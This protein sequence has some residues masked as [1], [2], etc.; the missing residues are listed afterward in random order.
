MY[1]ITSSQPPSIQPCPHVVISHLVMN[2]LSEYIWTNLK[3]VFSRSGRIYEEASSRFPHPGLSSHEKAGSYRKGCFMEF[4]SYS[5]SELEQYWLQNIANL[6]SDEQS[7]TLGCKVV[8]EQK[9]THGKWIKD[10]LA[11]RNESSN[12]KMSAKIFSHYVHKDSCTGK[13]ST[14]FIEPL[15][16]TLRTP[17]FPCIKKPR[18]CKQEPTGCTKYDLMS[19]D[20]LLMASSEDSKHQGFLWENIFLMLDPH[21]MMRVLGGLLTALSGSRKHTSHVALC[22]TMYL[23]GNLRC[24]LVIGTVCLATCISSSI[25]ITLLPHQRWVS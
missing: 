20:Y 13:L 21:S 19:T 4:V 3:F 18:T 6:Q 10:V 23:H 17:M 1:A 7:W 25:F 15:A 5:S 2:Q 16:S 14:R 11:T 24:F 8:E 9:H 22:L 12:T